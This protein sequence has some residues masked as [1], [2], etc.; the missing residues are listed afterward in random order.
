[1]KCKICGKDV[2]RRY[3]Q[4]H[5]TAIYDTDDSVLCMACA[6]KQIVPMTQEDA[7]F[8]NEAIADEKDK[9]KLN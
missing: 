3:E 5:D 4:L 7:D 2:V 9:I 1:M 6:N 8:L